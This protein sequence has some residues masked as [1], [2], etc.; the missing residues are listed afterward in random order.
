MG[1]FDPF[2]EVM[3]DIDSYS[4]TASYDSLLAFSVTNSSCPIW[5][6]FHRAPLWMFL[7]LVHCTAHDFIECNMYSYGSKF[8][9]WWSEISMMVHWVALES[10]QFSL[11]P[12]CT[13]G[14]L[15]VIILC[16]LTITYVTS[17]HSNKMWVR[18]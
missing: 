6:F 4:I 7:W 14:Y 12:I 16:F 11:I 10:E 2:L 18:Y 3:R 13:N 5:W 1:W 15:H 8:T 17:F 9:T